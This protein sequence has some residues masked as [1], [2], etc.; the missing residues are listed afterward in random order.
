MSI[1]DLSKSDIEL[2]I[3][4]YIHKERDRAILKR[5]LIDGICYEPLAEEFDLSVRQVKNIVYK[6]RDKLLS[7][8]I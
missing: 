3:D 7:H 1:N 5:R 4:E 8:V 2:L 6:S